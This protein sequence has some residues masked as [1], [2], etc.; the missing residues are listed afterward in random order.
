[1]EYV[2]ITKETV[3]KRVYVKA[4]SIQEAEEKLNNGDYEEGHEIDSY[5]FSILELKIV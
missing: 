2:A 4:Y 5:N 1:M 3:E